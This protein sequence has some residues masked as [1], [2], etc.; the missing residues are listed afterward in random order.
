MN[1]ELYH[2]NCFNYLKNVKSSSV[3]LVLIDPPYKVSEIQ[4]SKVAPR[5]EK[6]L[7]DL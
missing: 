3:D 4:I 2:D 5:Q 7:I 6:T 1:V